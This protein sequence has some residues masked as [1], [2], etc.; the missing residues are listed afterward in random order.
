VKTT[1]AVWHLKLGVLAGLFVKSGR[2]T[3]THIV[4]A[5]AKES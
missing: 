4:A 2:K 3:L 1:V 5:A